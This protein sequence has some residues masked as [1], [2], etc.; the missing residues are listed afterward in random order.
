MNY[1]KTKMNKYQHQSFYVYQLVTQVL[2]EACPP[3]FNRCYHSNCL[4]DSHFCVCFV[5]CLRLSLHVLS[6]VFR[7]FL[8][9]LEQDFLILRF[10]K[11]GINKSLVEYT[12]KSSDRSNNIFNRFQLIIAAQFSVSF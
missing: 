7:M 9:L 4:M 3:H 10:L 1:F 2:F 12:Q 6:V 8:S 5:S 11:V